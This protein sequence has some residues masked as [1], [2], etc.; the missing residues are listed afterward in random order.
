MREGQK[1]KSNVQS[2]SAAEPESSGPGLE[3]SASRKKL[4]LGYIPK[5]HIAG[6]SGRSISNFLRNL[7]VDFQ[8]GCT[9]FAI[10]PSSPTCVVT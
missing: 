7:Q 1:G 3:F 5:S 6:T 2:P 10:P 8:S 4:I 9:Q